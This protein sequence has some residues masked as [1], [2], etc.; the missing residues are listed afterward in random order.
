MLWGALAA[1]LLVV[2]LV[3]FLATRSSV[4]GATTPSRLVGKAAPTISST[5]A[6]GK[7]FELS[8]LRGRWVVVNFF[9]SWCGPC[10][11]EA[12]ELVAF[13]W[14]QQQVPNG[15]ELVSVVFNDSNAAARAFHAYYGARWPLVLDPGG[16]IAASYGVLA[17]PET[18][19]VNPEGKVV[20]ALPGGVT[21]VQLLAR[22]GQAKA[23]GRS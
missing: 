10:K 5:T 1:V 23:A 4:E 19:I 17:P 15:A 2:G 16:R 7:A 3:A 12:P 22:I 8:A 9:A 21:K 14:Q 20:D 18:F 13:E 6:D 11:A